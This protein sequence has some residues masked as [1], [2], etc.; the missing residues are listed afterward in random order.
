VV[1]LGPMAGS[2]QSCTTPKMPCMRHLRPP[3]L[4]LPSRAHHG[5]APHMAVALLLLLL[6][7]LP[8]LWAKF[9]AGVWATAAPP[10]ACS[11]RAAW[12]DWRI[13]RHHSATSLQLWLPTLR[14]LSAAL[15]SPRTAEAGRD[16]AGVT[17]ERS[18]TPCQKNQCEHR[19]GVCTSGSSSGG[20]QVASV[21]KGH[22]AHCAPGDEVWRIQY[23]GP[24]L[25]LHLSGL[26]SAPGPLIYE[27]NKDGCSV[28]AY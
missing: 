17:P 16:A 25:L 12:L 22:V 8:R 9:R 3:Q 5:Q 24:L 28:H 15:A 27:T 26:I 19:V 6:L 7:L 2:P 1:V 4:P 21:W 10:A 13:D 11:R 14:L 18:Q 20:K 23:D